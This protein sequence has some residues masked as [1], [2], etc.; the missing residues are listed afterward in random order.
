MLDI[1]NLTDVINYI[2]ASFKCGLQTPW[3]W[4]R[5]CPCA[6]HTGIQGQQRYSS[7]AYCFT[8]CKT[9]QSLTFMNPPYS[10]FQPFM[11]DHFNTTVLTLS[12]QFQWIRIR[13]IHSF[14]FLNI[15]LQVQP[16]GYRNC[17]ITYIHIC[18]FTDVTYWHITIIKF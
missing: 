4:H 12:A 2:L 8:T 17:H 11:N 7:T 9:G 1:M 16:S 14:L 3:G 13:F 5:C 18:E 10:W 6:L 15:L